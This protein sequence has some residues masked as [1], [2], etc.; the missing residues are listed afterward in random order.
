[1]AVFIIPMF[2]SSE[3][4]L[5]STSDLITHKLLWLMVK[6]K[7]R[8]GAAH[9]LVCQVV[10]GAKD[11]GALLTEGQTGVALA[12][13]DNVFVPQA[14]LM[15]IAKTSGMF[16]I[17]KSGA[18]AAE[19]S[20]EAKAA[21]VMSSS[22]SACCKDLDGRTHE[23]RDKKTIQT[24]MDRVQ[25]MTRLFSAERM[26]YYV[27]ELVFNCE[28]FSKTCLT[29]KARGKSQPDTHR[30]AGMH[31][32]VQLQSLSVMETGWDE[33]SRFQCAM[34]LE[35]SSMSHRKISLCDF[36]DPKLAST[37]SFEKD[38]STPGMRELARLAVDNL[39][40]FLA[41]YSHKDFLTALKVVTDSL[42]DD[43][44]LWRKMH[45]PFLLFR[46]SLMLENFGDDVRTQHRSEMDPELDLRDGPGCAKLLHMY[47][48]R[49]VKDAEELSNGC[50]ANGHCDYYSTDYGQ[51]DGIEHREGALLTPAAATLKRDLAAADLDADANE[52]AKRAKQ[53]KLFCSL[54]L[55]NKLAVKDG[56][57]TLVTCSKGA[58]C[59][60]NHIQQLSLMTMSTALTCTRFKSKD[61]LMQENFKTA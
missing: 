61:R 11:A 53:A 38:R 54:H 48:V 47:G 25:T 52:S 32:Y 21:A 41:A 37:K 17:P 15:E 13:I 4:E 9:N 58:A 22:S 31:R 16:T 45:D 55:A 33:G 29:L 20:G 36:L 3:T 43:F 8:A 60:Y 6:G 18:S 30:D 2:A 1:G 42:R 19:P 10:G 35:F 44:D 28:R 34:N 49:F 40:V 14:W 12:A 56:K 24:K 5:P 59:P 39:Q 50:T 46:L 27:A 23:C 51:H 26:L 7:T 57:G